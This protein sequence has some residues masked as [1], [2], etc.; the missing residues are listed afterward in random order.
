MRREKREKRSERAK[1]CIGS[2]PCQ[3]EWMAKG[4]L[5]DIRGSQYGISKLIN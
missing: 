5:R 2:R 4:E 3:V 1:E